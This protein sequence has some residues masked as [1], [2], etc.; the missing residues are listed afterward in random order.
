MNLSVHF[1]VSAIL[2]AALYQFFG[3]ISSMALAGG[4]LIDVDHIFS[5]AAKHGNF[6]IRKSY[7]YHRQRCCLKEGGGAVHIF[8]TLE[9][10]FLCLV[11]SFYSPMMLIFTLSYAIHQA[12]DLSG[13]FV[14][15]RINSKEFTHFYDTDKI[16]LKRLWNWLRD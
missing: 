16:L 6:S 3:P 10:F 2:A 5:Y 8:H 14:I 13:Y 4:F 9:F 1:I 11:L 15:K 12:L 7:Q